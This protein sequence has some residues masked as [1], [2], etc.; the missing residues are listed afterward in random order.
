MSSARRSVLAA[1]IAVIAAACMAPAVHAQAPKLSWQDCDD[2]FQCATATVPLDYGKPNRAT[3]HIALIRKVATGPG[4]R[5]GSLFTNPGG[6]GGGGVDFV[7]AT[8]DSL[9]ASLNQR[10]D[11]V[12]FDPRGTGESDAALSCNANQ[13]TE[14]I[15]SIPYATPETDRNALIAKD[16]AYVNKCTALNRAILPYVTTGN[17]ARDLDQLRQS[18]GDNKLNYLGFSYGTF[19]GATYGALFPGK[20]GRV[21]L[22]GPVDANG[23]INDPVGDL[24]AQTSAF[25]RALG[26]FF[27]DCAADQ[28]NCL[29]FGGADPWTAFDQLVEQANANPIPADGYTDDPRPVTGDDILNA[30][31][32]NLYAKQY[33]PYIAQDLA[34]A[35]AGD[36]S[37]VRLDSDGSFGRNPDGTYD[38]GTDRYFLI[39]AIDQQYKHNIDRY[40]RLGKRSYDAFDHFWFNSGYV[41]LNYGLFD[42]RPNGRYAGPFTL[43]A[44][45]NTPLVVAT[46]YDPATPYR[47]AKALVHDLGNAR[48]LTMQGDGHTAYGGNSPCI[49]DAVDAYLLNGALPAP[50]TVCQQEVPFAQPED[51]SGYTD[52]LTT[53]KLSGAGAAAFSRNR[54]GDVFH[55]KPF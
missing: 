19:I 50:G 10:Y 44:G 15:Y 29:G 35:A 23:Y 40:F 45:A 20:L 22:D 51:T 14:G 6:P 36:G 55:G 46:T 5:I 39:G 1:I 34:L 11:I 41:E 49:D 4:K 18:V 17:V 53:Q 26:R 38:P 3:Y 52:D 42:V 27:Q 43:P 2:G 54:A 7:R 37:L 24:Q 47:G 48:L 13:E 25:E 31:I 16:K 32:Y 21:V 28:T 12:G 33:W 9:Y 8:A 30:V